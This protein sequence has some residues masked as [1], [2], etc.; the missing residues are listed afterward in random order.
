MLFEKE[1][2]DAVARYMAPEAYDPRLPLTEK[3]RPIVRLHGWLSHLPA[4]LGGFELELA[5]L[6]SCLSLHATSYTVAQKMR[7]N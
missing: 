3:V 6:A 1:S 5:A 4:P 2:A 7:P